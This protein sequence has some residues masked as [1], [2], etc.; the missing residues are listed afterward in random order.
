MR[1]HTW[2]L[3]KISGYSRC[4]RCN[5][6]MQEYWMGHRRG[7]NLCKICAATLFN[8]MEKKLKEDER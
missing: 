3:V 1:N 6:Q 5:C 4:S 7:I 2:D 8:A